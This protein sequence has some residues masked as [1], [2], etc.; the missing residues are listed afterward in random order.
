MEIVT[1]DKSG[2][3]V[4]PKKVR[5]HFDGREFEVLVEKNAIVLKARKGFLGLFGKAPE[6][7]MPGFDRQRR[8]EIVDEDSA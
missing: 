4:L 2:R 7:D 8:K 5:D 1:V 6:L 3:V